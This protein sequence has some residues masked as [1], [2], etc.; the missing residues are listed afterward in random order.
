MKSIVPE[1]VDATF[2]GHVF[3]RG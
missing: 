2:L 3:L 1:I